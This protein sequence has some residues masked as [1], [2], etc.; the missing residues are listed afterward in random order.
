MTLLDRYLTRQCV[1]AIATVVGVLA[2]L[3]L[4]FAL[5]EELDEGNANYGFSQALQY[6]LL[7]MPRRIEELLSYGVFIGLLLALGNLA[8]GGELTAIRAA[9]VSPRRIIVALLPTLGICLAL[10]LALSEFLSPAGERAGVQSKQQA[11]LGQPIGASAVSFITP[12][13]GIWLRR[14]LD[15]GSEFAHIGGI[16]QQGRLVNVHV[17]QVNALNQLVASRQAAS[18]NFDA[19]KKQWLLQNV[20]T[21]ALSDRAIESFE[22]ATWVWANSVNPDQLATQAFSDPRKMTVVQIWQYLSRTEQHPIASIPFEL[23]LWQKVLTPLTYLSMALMALAVVIGPLRHTGIGQRLTIGL[24][25]GLGFK[26]LQDLF[27]PMAVVFNV[28]SVL[29]VMIPALIYLAVAQRMIRNN[30]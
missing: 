17:Y 16:D 22:E 28:P 1:I 24:F 23:T 26:Y 9:G 12:K 8:E 19:N 11:L 25:I 21:T 30:A 14:S 18:G 27:A 2:A 13:D 29:A 15:N 10:N 3:T 7:T 20:A 6:L 4:L 5:I